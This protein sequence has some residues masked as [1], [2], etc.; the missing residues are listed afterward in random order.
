MKPEIIIQ[1]FRTNMPVRFDFQK[2]GEQMVNGCLFDID[3]KTGKT[4]AIERIVLR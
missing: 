2:E 3:D 4:T 1:K